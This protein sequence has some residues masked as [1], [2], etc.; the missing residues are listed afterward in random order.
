MNW[1]RA[2]ERQRSYRYG[3]DPI[4]PGGGKFVR[5][6]EREAREVELRMRRMTFAE[7]KARLHRRV[8]HERP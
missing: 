7:V 4:S 5:K 6:A 3:S 2:N 1:E 8:D